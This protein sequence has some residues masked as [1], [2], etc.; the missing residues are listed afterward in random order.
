[1]YL[2]QVGCRVQYGKIIMFIKVDN[3]FFTFLLYFFYIHI[4][5]HKKYETNPILKIVSNYDFV[6]HTHIM[7]FGSNIILYILVFYSPIRLSVIF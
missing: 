3:I 7:L 5:C 6:T 2:T 4:S 1:M